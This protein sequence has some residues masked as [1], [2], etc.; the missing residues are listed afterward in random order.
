M[1]RFTRH[2]LIFNKN[3]LIDAVLFM[4]WKYF[5]EF[6]RKCIQIASNYEE[7]LFII[8]YFL[9]ARIWVNYISNRIRQILL[10]LMSQIFMIIGISFLI[11]IKKKMEPSSDCIIKGK[12]PFCA[13]T[14]S[15]KVFCDQEYHRFFISNTQKFSC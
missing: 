6:S 13:K 8:C 15:A 4:R 14:F 7:F 3:A 11:T 1:I 12:N 9:N 10:L 2:L 5:F